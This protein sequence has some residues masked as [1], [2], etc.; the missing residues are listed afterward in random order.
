[1]SD[2]YSECQ[3]VLLKRLFHI[4]LVIDESFISG[5]L[6]KSESVISLEIREG[7]KSNVTNV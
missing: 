4:N 7:S 5:S 2:E 1:M 6:S 3:Q